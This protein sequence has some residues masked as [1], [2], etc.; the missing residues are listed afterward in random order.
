MGTDKYPDEN[1]FDAYL[2][3]NGGESNAHTEV[4]WTLFHMQ[5][6]PKGLAKAMDMFGRFFAAP[7]LNR[8][9]VSREVEAIESEFAE[10]KRLDDARFDEV[11][12]RAAPEGHPFAT[13]CWGNAE[14][15]RCG[16]DRALEAMRRMHRDHYHASNM[17]L[18]VVSTAPL[19]EVEMHVARSFADVR[20]SPDTAY[21]GD[22]N[23]DDR[24]CH[25]ARPNGWNA[26]PAALPPPLSATLGRLVRITAVQKGVQVSLAWPIGSVVGSWR[27]RPEEIC[28]HVLG[29][30]G[31]SSA[32]AAL[33][34]RGLCTELAAGVDSDG[35]S[36]SAACGAV[37]CI[38]LQLAKAAEWATAVDIVL[39]YAATCAAD[40]ELPGRVFDEMAR[41]AQLRFDYAIERDADEL[42]E[43][44]AVAMLPMHCSYPRSQLLAAEGGVFVERDDEAVAK[45]LSIISNPRACRIEIANADFAVDVAP[46]SHEATTAD[47]GSYSGPRRKPCHGGSSRNGRR[48]QCFA[49]SLDEVEAKS[50]SLSCDSEISFG[51]YANLATERPSRPPLVEAHFGVEYWDDEIDD[52]LLSAWESPLPRS[53]DEELK[54]PSKNEFIATN[55]SLVAPSPP[56]DLDESKAKALDDT[57][58][59]ELT[60]L[61]TAS[62]SSTLP[63]SLTKSRKA[64]R[65]SYDRRPVEVVYE[66]VLGDAFPLPSLRGLDAFPVVVHRS[67]RTTLYHAQRLERFALPHCE[68]RVRLHPVWDDDSSPSSCAARLAALE[69]LTQIALDALADDLYS[70]TDAELLYSLSTRDATVVV[71]VSGFSEPLPKLLSAVLDGVRTSAAALCASPPTPR[72]LGVRNNYARLLANSW[73]E[74][75]GHHARQLRLYLLCPDVAVAPDAKLIALETEQ[76]PVVTFVDAEVLVHGNADT[77]FA[78]QT[79][80]VVKCVL[81]GDLLAPRD[82]SD[83]VTSLGPP[84]TT[85]RVVQPSVDPE[86]PTTALEVYWQVG[87]DSVAR[88]VLTE[89]LEVLLEEPIYDELR[90]KDQLGYTVSCGSRWTAGVVGF[91]ARIVSDKANPAVLEQ[92]L[93]T[94]FADFRKK[95]LGNKQFAQKILLNHCEALVQRK[96]EKERAY[97][98]L[99]ARD[100]DA[101]V[102]ALPFD[103]NIVDAYMIRHV[104]AQAVRDFYDWV[105]GFNGQ[106]G[107]PKLVVSV[108]GPRSKHPEIFAGAPLASGQT[109]LDGTRIENRHLVSA[110][111]A[112][113]PDT[114]HRRALPELTNVDASQK[115]ACRAPTIGTA[116]VT[117]QLQEPR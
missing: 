72:I 31:A 115:I 48:S 81:S 7:M 79:E 4:E 16:D 36:N 113:F 76:L 103:L 87:P 84:G 6:L 96:L 11:L 114:I 61:T 86:S 95:T 91:G 41:V 3:K 107:A 9:C 111:R 2:S 89:I 102:D 8:E 92:R 73:Q 93:D 66:Q 67:E 21:T 78:L 17:K 20:A 109:D 34:R 35:A 15:L 38:V 25:W 52:T 110:F 117:S 88:R 74:E 68:I 65:S 49:L 46:S 39:R 53:Y 104:S 29:H 33:R 101:I 90:T 55:L 94:F 69:L 28:A 5:V 23:D 56:V 19:G 40:L 10:V 43:D 75:V 112:R 1:A 59:S 98:A 45:I 42:A 70:A 27:A 99:A 71:H 30:E 44:I 24:P 13:F 47:D 105:F 60:S 64:K 80:H 108:V 57:V 100:F 54:P 58:V 106:L 51:A 97:D 50:Q 77:E 62:S 32:T 22:Q 82:G 26:P 116:I 63:S 12:H 18:V 85:C 83:G 37:F 14:T